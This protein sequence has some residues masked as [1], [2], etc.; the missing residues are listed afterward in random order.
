[1]GHNLGL[2][3]ADDVPGA[4]KCNTQSGRCHM[5]NAEI[6]EPNMWTNCTLRDMRKL[7]REGKLDCKW[8]SRSAMLGTR[9]NEKLVIMH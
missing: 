3:H 2:I 7:A 5:M 8:H 9:G 6:Y 1:M 4:C